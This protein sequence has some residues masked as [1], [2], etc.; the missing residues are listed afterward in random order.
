MAVESRRMSSILMLPYDDPNRAYEWLQSAF[1][2]ERGEEPYQDE[3]GVINHGELFLGDTCVALAGPYE[4]M[5]TVSPRSIE[6]QNTAFLYVYVDDVDA[7]HA[8]A[9][10][11]GAEVK[12]APADQHYGDRNYRVLD[13]EGR[14]WMFG[15]PIK[16]S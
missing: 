11:A 5:R 4:L 12:E 13:C 10:A 8:H 1:G 15:S 6:G 7:H 3:H 2:F 9:A 14:P 16:T